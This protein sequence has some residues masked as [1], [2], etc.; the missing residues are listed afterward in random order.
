MGPADAYRVPLPSRRDIHTG[1]LL[2][3]RFLKQLAAAVTVTTAAAY[4]STRALASPKRPLRVGVVGGGI[5]G[6][7]LA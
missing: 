3:R 7:S 6:A 4:G 2:R 5:V 1:P